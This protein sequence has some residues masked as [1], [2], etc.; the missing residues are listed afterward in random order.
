M[1][2]VSAGVYGGMRS[3]TSRFLAS[4]LG[5]VTATMAGDSAMTYVRRGA[6]VKSRDGIVEV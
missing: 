3:A 4:Q 6:Y 1:R 5:D 2:L